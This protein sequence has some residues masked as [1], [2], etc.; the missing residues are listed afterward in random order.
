[1]L[2]KQSKENKTRV[3]YVLRYYY[4]SRYEDIGW[5]KRTKKSYKKKRQVLL[6]QT[7]NPNFQI[8]NQSK[9]NNN[10]ERLL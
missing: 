8:H 9:K 10:K 7:E 5:Y 6:Y 4:I 1:M 2:E 3:Y